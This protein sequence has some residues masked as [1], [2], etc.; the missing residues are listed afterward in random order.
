MRLLGGDVMGAKATFE[1]YNSSPQ[2]LVTGGVSQ[3]TGYDATGCS[4]KAIGSTGIKL[5]K[6][7]K[8][9]VLVSADV[10]GTG[11]IE[12]QL[13]QDDVAIP[14]AQ[15]TATSTGATDL[16][17]LAFQKVICVNDSCKCINNNTILTVVNTGVG[18]V[19]N[20]ITVDVVK[21]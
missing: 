11:N 17:N 3:F 19:V 12:L 7:G 2:E 16:C 15:A 6:S 18:S 21:L 1:A 14:Y 13:Y 5:N 20:N 9:L 8:Y 10:S 4:I